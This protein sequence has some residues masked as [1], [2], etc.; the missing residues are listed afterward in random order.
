MRVLEEFP[1]YARLKLPG[2]LDKDTPSQIR[3]VNFFGM[4]KTARLGLG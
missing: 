3:F 2:D 4:I 1:F